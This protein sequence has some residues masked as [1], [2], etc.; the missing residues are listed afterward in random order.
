MRTFLILAL[1]AAVPAGELSQPAVSVRSSDG[2]YVV[3]ARFEVDAPVAVVRA[4]LTDYAGIP[5][6]MPDVRKSVVRQRDGRIVLVEQEAV[7]KV[8]MF[9][10]TVHM[11]LEVTEGERVLSFRDLCGTDFSRYEGSWTL[12]ARG[13]GTTVSYAL[14]ADPSFSVPSFM[15]KRLLGGNARDTIESLQAETARRASRVN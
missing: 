5:D 1:A 2:V 8:M 13:A 14:T 6:F 4:V 15:L 7:S 12:D 3:S 10:K 11:L 9:S